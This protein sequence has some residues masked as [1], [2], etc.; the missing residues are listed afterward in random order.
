METEKKM[1]MEKTKESEMIDRMKSQIDE[2]GYE[3]F[4]ELYNAWFSTNY[5]QSNVNWDINEPE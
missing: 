4:L 1:I 3:E 5:E 2:V